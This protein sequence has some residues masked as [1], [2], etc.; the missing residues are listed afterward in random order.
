MRNEMQIRPGADI[1][2][3]VVGAFGATLVGVGGL[4][5]VRPEAGASSTAPA[6]DAF[7][8]AA[9]V[10]ALALAKRGRPAPIGAFLVGFGAID[11]YQA[12]ASHRHWFPES[13]FRWTPT[14]DRLHLTVGTALVVLGAWPRSPKA[15]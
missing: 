14:D 13:L 12:L 10:A 1:R 6:Y 8:L 4:G 15:D 5:F 2:R 3:W 11:L 7:H 9:G